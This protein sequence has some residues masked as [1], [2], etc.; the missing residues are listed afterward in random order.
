MVR[1]WPSDDLSQ[2]PSCPGPRLD[3]ERS[4]AEADATVLPYLSLLFR[5][6]S[7][8]VRPCWTDAQ[9]ERLPPLLEAQVVDGDMERCLIDLG[10]ADGPKQLC[11]V[12][13]P[14]AHEA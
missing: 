6:E 4:I 2:A 5:I 8:H 12:S 9:S 7:R 10:E 11:Q 13:F 3:C 1:S 14:S